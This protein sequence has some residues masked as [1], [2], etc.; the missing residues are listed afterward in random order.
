MVPKIVPQNKIL[1]KHKQKKIDKTLHTN[2]GDNYL[3][4]HLVQLLQDKINP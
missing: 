1:I 3:T 4:N 2:V